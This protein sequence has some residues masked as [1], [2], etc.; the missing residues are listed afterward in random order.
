MIWPN[1]RSSLTNISSLIIP[2][3]KRGKFI[4]IVKW[5][6]EIQQFAQCPLGKMCV[7]A[8]RISSQLPGHSQ[9]S[10]AG[11]IQ[12]PAFCCDL[13]ESILSYMFLL[14]PVMSSGEMPIE[15]TGLK[16]THVNV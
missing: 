16:K 7:M 4:L 1:V 15:M 13:M 11:K 8:P 9:V 2:V 14:R 6:K 5:E 12:A 3:S 10:D